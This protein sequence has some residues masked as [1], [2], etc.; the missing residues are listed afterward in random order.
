MKESYW[1][2]SFLKIWSQDGVFSCGQKS[3]GM[4]TNFVNKAYPSFDDKSND[5]CSF[6]LE[7][8]DASVCQIRVDFVD[9]KLLEPSDGNCVKQYLV[10]K[11]Q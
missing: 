9:T 3:S 4:T 6:L 10:I 7:I 8:S 1:L 5:Q 11:A 2:F